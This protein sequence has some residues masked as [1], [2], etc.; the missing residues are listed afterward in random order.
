VSVPVSVPVSV[1]RL[2][3]LGCLQAILAASFPHPARRDDGGVK[4]HRRP[5]CV[6]PGQGPFNAKYEVSCLF[7]LEAQAQALMF[8][9]SS[10]C[11][12]ATVD[13]YDLAVDEGAC[14]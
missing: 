4:Y 7:R 11:T 14:R 9:S 12:R 13:A 2:N 5:A 10:P 1:K 3:Q 8:T 6:R